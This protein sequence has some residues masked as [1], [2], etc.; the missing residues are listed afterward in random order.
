MPIALLAYFLLEALAFYGVAQLIGV[1]WA[2]FWIFGLMFVG[3]ALASISLRG[4]L[5]RSAAGQTTVE[6]LAGDSALLLVGWVLSI[7]PGYVTSLIGL[8]LIFG[9]TRA[10][11][12]RSLTAQ[13]QRN[14]EEFSVRVFNSSP[15]ARTR[16]SYGDFGRQQPGQGNPAT[17]GAATTE[18][19]GTDHPV[20]DADELE[21]WFRMD[22]PEG[23]NS[24]ES[25]P[26]NSQPRRPGEDL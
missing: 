15:M 21:K 10:V 25:G 18:P 24:P 22:G 12:R 7:I 16:T 23:P 26:E 5:S 20:I 17:P 3:G 9:P 11:V 13:L 2:L 19:T 8:L 4:A 1:G 6:K 14:V